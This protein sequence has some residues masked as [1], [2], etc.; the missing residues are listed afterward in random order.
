MLINPYH[1]VGRYSWNPPRRLAVA[2]GYT[3]R[4]PSA[5]LPMRRIIFV[6]TT[7]IGLGLAGGAFAQGGYSGGSGGGSSLSGGS[8][9]GGSSSFS[10]GGMSLSG[11]S[12][13]FSGGTSVTGTTSFT[14]GT[15]FTG[16][17]SFSGGNQFTGGG[18]SGGTTTPGGGIRGG[19]GGTTFTPSTTN[20]EA[21][22]WANP[23]YPG[24]PGSTNISNKTPGGFGQPSFGA[25]NA[26]RTGTATVGRGT[27]TTTNSFGIVVPAQSPITY[28]LDVRF[29][30]PPIAAPRVQADLQGIINHTPHLREP[31]NVHVEVSGSTVI[32]RG[33]VA[34]DEERRL[35]E[36]IVRLEPG[37]HDV[38][39]ELEVPSG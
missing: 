15:S 32:L 26:G 27:G 28:T 25:V 38:R 22:T 10:G 8:S 21:K 13:S 23:L 30:A 29:Q 18:I 1:R 34:D 17:T 39:N 35:I 31:G 33:R 6:L 3:S 4:G 11:G 20:F 14:G 36:G 19:A 16:T 9:F 37:V 12:S 7:A 5:E 24:R 2:G